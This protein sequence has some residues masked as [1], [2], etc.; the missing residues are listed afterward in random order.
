MAPEPEK[1]FVVNSRV[2]CQLW[3][4]HSL[5]SVACVWFPYTPRAPTHPLRSKPSRVTIPLESPLPCCS[6]LLLSLRQ[7]VFTLKLLQYT[8]GFNLSFH[9]RSI[10]CHSCEWTSRHFLYTRIT[11][12][13]QNFHVYEHFYASRRYKTAGHCVVNLP[14][15]F[16]LLLPGGV[17]LTCLAVLLPTAL[18]R[19]IPTGQDGGPGRRSH[20]NLWVQNTAIKLL[21]TWGGEEK[22]TPYHTCLS[23]SPSYLSLAITDLPPTPDPSLPSSDTTEE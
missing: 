17:S 3:V 11:S 10:W 4:N 5:S 2:S 6:F 23:G 14:L 15:S 8:V 13:P 16:A 22:T 21:K 20:R 9:R 12:L 7:A 19:G 1:S 18:Q